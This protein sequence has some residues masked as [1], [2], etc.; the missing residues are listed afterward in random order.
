MKKCDECLEVFMWD[1]EV[2]NVG[3]RYWHRGCVELIPINYGAYVGDEYI[4]TVDYED[5]AF[6]ILNEGDYLEVSE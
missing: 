3:D 1:D 2:V 4:G 5:L 6:S